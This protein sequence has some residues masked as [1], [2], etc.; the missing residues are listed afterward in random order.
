[1]TG[2]VTLVNSLNIEGNVN[3]ILVDNGSLT[4]GYDTN[5]EN[6][7]YVKSNGKLTIYGQS[8]GTGRLEVYANSGVAGIGGDGNVTGV[9]YIWSL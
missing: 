2:D 4:A 8:K 5:K 6:P 3:I 1:M 7:V 9:I